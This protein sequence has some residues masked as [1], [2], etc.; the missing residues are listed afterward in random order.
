MLPKIKNKN[1][2]TCFVLHRR[3]VRI[4]TDIS[5]SLH[6]DLQQPVSNVQGQEEVENDSCVV[7]SYLTKN[8]HGKCDFL[9]HL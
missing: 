9:A 1:P 4:S 2:K 8:S 5:F 3:G 6:G 7:T